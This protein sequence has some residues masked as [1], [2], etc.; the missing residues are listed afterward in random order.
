MSDITT[1]STYS[2]GNKSY[3]NSG[4]SGMVSGID[5]DSLVEKLL[6]GTQSKID[7]QEQAKQVL[8]WKQD[9][10]Q[11][12]ITSINTF[13]STYFDTAFDSSLQTNLV[14]PDFFNSMTSAVTSG[15]DCVKVTSSTP[16]A[17][18]GNMQVAVTQLA[19]A[20]HLNG[21]ASLSSNQVSGTIDL[22]KF[23]P[24]VVT[25]DVKD[26]S[27]TSSVS[28]D[29][30]GVS[31][32]SDLVSKLNSSLN[33]H[34][35]SAQ[36]T[37]SGALSFTT[38]NNSISVAIDSSQST[39]SGLSTVGLSGTSISSSSDTLGA[40]I[41]YGID[42]PNLTA[43]C[44]FN[45]SLNGV[46]KQISVDPQ[47]TYDSDTGKYSITLEN[48]RDAFEK[49]ILT[50]YGGTSCTKSDSPDSYDGTQSGYLNLKFGTSNSDPA[51]FSLSLADPSSSQFTVTGAKALMLG[52]TPGAS[53]RISTSSKLSE[54]A[55]TASGDVYQFTINNQQFTF[56]EDNTLYDVINTVN[57]SSAGVKM[58]YSSLSDNFSMESTST[59]SNYGITVSQQQGNLLTKLFGTVD[60]NT[61][62]VGNKASGTTLGTSSIAYNGNSAMLSGTMNSASFQVNV[63]GKDYSFSA[64]TKTDSAAY[65]IPEAIS[66][67]S[68]QMNSTNIGTSESPLYLGNVLSFEKDGSGNYTGNLT[69]TGNH[70]VKFAQST[71]PA[72]KADQ[73]QEEQNTNLAYRLGFSVSGKSNIASE[74]TTVG[75]LST[76]AQTA[77][78]SVSG[79]DSSTTLTQAASELQA[80]AQ[81]TDANS[82]ISFD[83]T[84]NRFSANAAALSALQ[85]SNVC[86][87][88]FNG[89]YDSS[90]N[91]V[92]NVSSSEPASVNVSQGTDAEATI[93]I[94][95]IPTSVTRSS[96]T[97]SM[98][99]VNFE[100]LQKTDD[101][102]PAT[103]STSRDA[104]TIVKT[105]KGFVDDYNKLVKSL[106]AYTDA[107]PTYRDYAPLTDAQ[108]EDMKDSE[109]TEWTT[110][111]KEG[112]LH[113]DDTI[114]TFLNN[115]RTA[116][117]T[118]PSDSQ[119]A[120]YN[121]GIETE[122][123]TAGSSSI[124]TLTFDESAFRSAL[125]TDP[126][127]VMNLFT[128]KEAG[129]ARQLSDACD[130]V[131]K[132]SLA[133]PGTLVQLSGAANTSWTNANNEI[134]SQIKDVN[135][136][137][138]DLKE[139]YDDERTR[140]WNE[141]NNM[142][143]A[144]SNLDSQTSWLTSE[145]SS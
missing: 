107:D 21:S 4:F 66:T 93:T 85:N 49:S 2:V 43:D 99:G 110:K 109:I 3:S 27:S 22:S 133:D 129:V 15:S 74:N 92:G 31:S 121:I 69:V 127:S 105:V 139:K 117:Y 116:L 17:V 35:V 59:G 108:K 134:Y 70:I 16:D 143:T 106:R 47:A 44:N 64:P 79:I 60:G 51:S 130:N 87:F 53:S 131:A 98:N 81:N 94:N 136:K 14:N 72:Y 42:S 65:S 71:V 7:K 118:K 34:D 82:Q 122:E 101:S 104:D 10:Y 1:S 111:A 135:N 91:Y 18:V 76:E 24:R 5:T 45:I 13:K 102:S 112:L 41:L 12:I 28:I 25:F 50:A 89:L 55:G 37:N 128:D 63:D 73:V 126:Q 95:G 11:G 46:T 20:A 137:I 6:S 113:N 140:Y 115:M 124:G 138:S 9:M 36:M 78:E 80:F 40:Q 75:Q 61:I 52:I 32:T 120:M 125:S 100:L 114:L 58:S 39:A 23:T 144:M 62:G 141:F 48:V 8:E 90:G 57:N 119:Y 38:G 83:T 26:G 145:F 33:T 97:F 19:S 54:L 103:I 30:A 68:N 123:Y 96:N 67:I 84:T 56:N 86:K 77:L 29:L 88:L 132:I 142:E